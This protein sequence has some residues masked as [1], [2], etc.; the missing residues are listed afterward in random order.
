MATVGAFSGSGA[1]TLDEDYQAELL[2]AL[3]VLLKGNLQLQMGHHIGM[4]R[5]EM[6]GG[7]RFR[8][9]GGDDG[10]PMRYGAGGKSLFTGYQIGAEIAQSASSFNDFRM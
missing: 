5:V 10:G 2:K 6:F 7:R 1:H 8:T 9:T 4:N 3:L